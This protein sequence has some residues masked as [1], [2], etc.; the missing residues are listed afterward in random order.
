M[1]IKRKVKIKSVSLFFCYCFIL[2]CHYNIFAASKKDYKVLIGLSPKDIGKCYGY[3]ELVIDA[4]FFSQE[5]IDVLHKNGNAAIF[6][7][8]NIG[9]LENFRSD[10]QEFKYLTL[11]EYENW[12][13]EKWVNT[14]DLNWQ[15]RIID[16]AG[17]LLKK[18]IDGFFLDNADVYYHYCTD[19]IYKGLVHIITAISEFGKPIIINGADIFMRAAIEKNDLKGIVYGI[20]QECVFTEIDFIKKTFGVK[21]E[22]ERAYF[23]HYL[24]ICKSHG[25]KVYLLEYGT[26]KSFENR[27]RNY[28]NQHGFVYDIS[29]SIELNIP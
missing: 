10:Y 22:E 5:E 9:S 19:E 15:K 16:K 14:G 25:L 28:C 21:D 27:I 24:K 29:T 17:I 1:H 20:N 11:G 26:S 13:E 2:S 3:D 18:N 23:Q 12:S 4:D 7:Y 6:S 8:L